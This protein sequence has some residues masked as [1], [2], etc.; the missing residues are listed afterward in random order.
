MAK[1][2][3]FRLA[4]VYN[5][6]DYGA[7]ADGTTDDMGHIQAAVDAAYAAG[8]GVVIAPAGSYAL[9]SAAV[10]NSDTQACVELLEGVTLRGAGQGLT[11]FLNSTNYAA[12]FG[13]SETQ[14]V[15]LGRCTIYTTGTEANGTKFY[16]TDNVLV[17]YVTAHGSYNGIALYSCAGSLVSN[18]IAYG[19]SNKGI[20]VSS[21]AVATFTTPS[22][23]NYAYNVIVSDCEA[24]DCLAS[25]N[26]Q[27]FAAV[28]RTH[29]DANPAD[30]QYISFVRC[31]AHGNDNMGF[32][33]PCVDHVTLTDCIATGHVDG[34]G[35]VIMGGHYVTTTGT[36]FGTNSEN[37][38]ILH[39]TS[40]VGY[41]YTDAPNWA[42][43]LASDNLTI[44][45]ASY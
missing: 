35:I 20:Q 14:R 40:D 34:G 29:T 21:G 24:Y 32:F 3:P 16:A 1:Y 39:E 8:G 43:F 37:V 18:C 27:G 41:Y 30:A 25:G 6:M 45:G 44:E 28:G 36:T 4:T 13:S 5:V 33:L 7:H 15:G 11:T 10:I 12:A 9:K 26:A 38:K 31:N 42:K 23:K 17:D 19:C 2:C 22:G